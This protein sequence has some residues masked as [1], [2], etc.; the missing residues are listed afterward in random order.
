MTSRLRADA[1]EKRCRNAD[2]RPLIGL[3]LRPPSKITMI[4]EMVQPGKIAEQRP[5]ISE[6][7]SG[8]ESV[9]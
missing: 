6:I 4:T 7:R 8:D 9:L 5:L 2:A 3:R 1:R